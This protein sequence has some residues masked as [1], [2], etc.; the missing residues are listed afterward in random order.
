MARRHAWSGAI[1]IQADLC[2]VHRMDNRGEKRMSDTT[3]R[4]IEILKRLLEE[5]QTR[6]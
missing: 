6:K 3:N 5:Q 2:H 1:E 4:Q